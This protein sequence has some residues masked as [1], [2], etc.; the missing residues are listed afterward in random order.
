MS[1]PLG[2]FLTWTTYGTWLPGDER[3]RVK[4]S[5]FGV[6]EPDPRIRA[7][8]SDNM[9]EPAVILTPKQR[10]IVDGVIV[11]HRRIRRWVLH[12]RNVRT[13]HVHVVLTANR[14]PK[15]V[16]EQLKAWGS[17]RLSDHAGL[18]GEGKDGRRRWWT[19]GGD[20]VWIRSEERLQ[21]VIHY[22]L[23]LQ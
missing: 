10:V 12:A 16:R 3:G 2:Y 11:D 7:V 13:N 4:K 15:T 22:V 23:E 14:D 20:D 17:R 18:Q 21:E 6:Q 8:A 9:S 1:E 19:E 5:Q